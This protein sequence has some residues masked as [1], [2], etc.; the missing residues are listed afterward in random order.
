[1]LNK[2]NSKCSCTA[3]HTSGCCSQMLVI[4]TNLSRDSADKVSGEESTLIGLKN[5]A[6][7]TL[8]GHLLLCPEQEQ[9]HEYSF[10]ILSTLL[11]VC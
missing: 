7:R 10:Q 11:V 6:G 2:N 9:L 1:M 3:S 5:R 8:T 4:L